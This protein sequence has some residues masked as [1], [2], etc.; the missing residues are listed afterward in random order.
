MG[1]VNLELHELL[2]G[3][4]CVHRKQSIVCRNKK[5]NLRR[6]GEWERAGFV[7]GKALCRY[8]YGYWRGNGVVGLLRVR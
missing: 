1:M 3:N 2:K 5:R 4:K 8:K 6:V 7:L